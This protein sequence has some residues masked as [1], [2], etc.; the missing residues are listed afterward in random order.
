MS[1]VRKYLASDDHY[2][3]QYTSIYSAVSDILFIL[4]LVFSQ[5]CADTRPNAVFSPSRMTFWS[6][7]WY[8][9]HSWVSWM[10]QVQPRTC[11]TRSTS[12]MLIGPIYHLLNLHPS[13]TFS[14]HCSLYRLC[15]RPTMHPRKTICWHNKTVR[16]VSTIKTTNLPRVDSAT[17]S[18]I[19]N[20]SF[21]FSVTLVLHCFVCTLSQTRAI[22]CYYIGHRISPDSCRLL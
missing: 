9:C 1:N 6:Q 12:T 18:D 7:H 13:P 20:N 21:A 4:L 16:S 3:H 8:I 15:C 10:T 17:F 19:W 22:K 2:S 5:G 14:R 11:R